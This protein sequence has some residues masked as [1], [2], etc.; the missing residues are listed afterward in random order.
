VSNLPVAMATLALCLQNTF[1]T[2]DV[3]SDLISIH[4]SHT[5]RAFRVY[6]DQVR[7]GNYAVTESRQVCRTNVLYMYAD[8]LK[9]TVEWLDL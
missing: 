3:I 8:L 9:V 1:H 5:L 4:D 7:I 2:W 6:R